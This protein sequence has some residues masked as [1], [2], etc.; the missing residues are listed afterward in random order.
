MRF[1]G[2]LALL[3]SPLAAQRMAVVHMPESFYGKEGTFWLPR[4]SI[5][6]IV[7]P[8]SD[9]VWIGNV[10]ADSVQHNREPCISTTRFRVAQ[11][12]VSVDF[13]SRT[14]GK[15]VETPNFR[16]PLHD[17]S[18]LVVNEIYR[19]YVYCGQFAGYLVVFLQI[20]PAGLPQ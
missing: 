3:A 13:H 1:L 15:G 5:M 10:P 16:L 17:G 18:V 20:N 2:L 7:L 12:S 9:T 19:R 11:D 8:S 14:L 4:N 6:G